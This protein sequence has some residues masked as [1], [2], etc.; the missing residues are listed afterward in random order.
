[1]RREREPDAVVTTVV[2][3]GRSNSRRRYPHELDDARSAAT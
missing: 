3:D 1:M 2:V